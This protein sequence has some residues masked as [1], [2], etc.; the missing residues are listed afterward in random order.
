[1]PPKKRKTS[2][3]EDH[4]SEEQNN[5][6]DTDLNQETKEE[7]EEESTKRSVEQTTKS[8]RKR[9][10]QDLEEPLGQDADKEEEDS[11][12]PIDPS[13]KRIKRART[14]KTPKKTTNRP[15]A[16]EED[17]EKEDTEMDQAEEEEE[18]SSKAVAKGNE[19]DEAKEQDEKEEEEIKKP[20][21]K[22]TPAKKKKAAP[23]K[24]TPAAVVRKNGSTETEEEM[25]TE[26]LN[27]T[28]EDS[29]LPVPTRESVENDSIAPAAS[30]TMAA[31]STTTTSAVATITTT[32]STKKSTVK[33]NNKGQPKITV[34][35]EASTNN[36]IA[37]ED[38]AI[39]STDADAEQK[40]DYLAKYWVWLLIFLTI[41][42]SAF[43]FART[44]VM[45]TLVNTSDFF[46]ELYKGVYHKFP[47]FSGEKV[48]N[49]TFVDEYKL[50]V[51]QRR[52]EK[53]ALLKEL[54]KIN[55][56]MQLGVKHIDIDVTDFQ[57]D[58]S[59]LEEKVSEHGEDPIKKLHEKLKQIN[60]LLQVEAKAE[61][62]HHG[63]AALPAI[64]ETLGQEESAKLLDLSSLDLWEI[65]EMPEG[66]DNSELEELL[67]ED[68]EDSIDSS[69]VREA[70]MSSTIVLDQERLDEWLEEIQDA[71]NDNFIEITKDES[72]STRVGS[73][74]RAELQKGV[75]WDRAVAKFT[76][77]E[78]TKLIQSEKSKALS[79]DEGLDPN[80][81]V[82][83]IQERLEVEIAD[84]TGRFDFASVRNGASVIREGPRATTR[85]LV[86][87]LPV[88]NRLLAHTGLRFYGHGAEAALMPTDPPDGLGQ[89][90]SFIS[91]EY[92]RKM[93]RQSLSVQDFSRGSVATLAIRLVRPV[94]VH[95]VVIEH[96]PRTLTNRI[97]SAI[98][99]F[100]VVGYDDEKA[101]TGSY[102]LGRFEYKI[103]TEVYL[104]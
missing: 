89:C 92:L 35:G 24:K 28:G 93:K 39:A 38:D 104:C 102:E 69:D 20:A 17:D 3:G 40:M 27:G 76:A 88:F 52:D 91:E 4:E 73:W 23:K 97:Q 78:V 15:R 101:T 2:D 36:D 49:Q 75:N 51:L 54:K 50:Q 71:I 68:S 14:D 45:P 100:R 84:K 42:V 1:M 56:S 6:E 95:S 57:N 25:A 16:A 11:E 43:P 46:L 65:P 26:G 19:K 74:A 90:W 13:Q 12:D 82:K 77:E 21:A 44:A 80:A 18:E 64:K 29:D 62:T 96:P 67:H 41:Q 87:D 85:S 9:G 8:A 72:I 66:C 31:T 32:T 30:L 7:E 94:H 47:P 48:I 34:N 70:S 22:K 37:Q 83:Q 98:R 63:M 60:E 81:I 55:T 79:G 99:V 5:E 53:R 103:G 33:S 59:Y 86:Q 61:E 58:L 10:R